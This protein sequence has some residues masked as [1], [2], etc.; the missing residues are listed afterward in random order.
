M[1]KKLTFLSDCWIVLDFGPSFRAYFSLRNYSL[2][3]KI[4]IKTDEISQK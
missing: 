1:V 4:G 2:L 3:A